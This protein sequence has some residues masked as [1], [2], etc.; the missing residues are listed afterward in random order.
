MIARL[1]R[2]SERAIRQV[3]ASTEF[4]EP[5]QSPNRSIGPRWLREQYQVRMRSFKDIAAGTGIPA[6]TLAAAARTARIPVRHGVNG[7]AHPLASLGRP[8]T[9]PP[10]V[11]NA[12]TRPNAAKRISRLL[13]LPGQASPHSAARQLGIRHAILASQI[14]QLETVTGTA[15]L[16]TGPNGMIVLTPDG[17]QFAAMSVPSSKPSR[18]PAR[19]TPITHHEPARPRNRICPLAR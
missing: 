3:L 14:R 17:G 8:G 18:S 2:S 12:F 15:L 9:F 16:R 13:A 11:W 1:T 5:T 6:E 4:R 7:R 10:A 19:R